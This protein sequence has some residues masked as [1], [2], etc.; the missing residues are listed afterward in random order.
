MV[1]IH[2]FGSVPYAEGQPRLASHEQFGIRGAPFAW[3]Q[4]R[5]ERRGGS[6]ARNVIVFSDPQKR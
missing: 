3:V 1:E 4:P 2:A 6:M 5:I